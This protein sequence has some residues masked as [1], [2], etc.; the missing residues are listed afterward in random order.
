[1]VPC[2][3]G[4][5][6]TAPEVLKQIRPLVGKV[7]HLARVI[8]DVEDARSEVCPVQEIH[9]TAGWVE[10]LRF[11]PTVVAIPPHC[12]LIVLGRH[13]ILHSQNAGIRLR[14]HDLYG[15]VD[16]KHLPAQH[17]LSVGCSAV[18]AAGASIKIG[19]T[20]TPSTAGQES[21]P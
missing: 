8:H 10:D 16:K 13:V 15:A 5:V 20:L 14:N 18:V 3:K 21:S 19:Q 2:Q 7:V 9:P 11:K 17:K 4:S 6:Q 12:G 1:M